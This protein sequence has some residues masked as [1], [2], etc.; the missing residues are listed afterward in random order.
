MRYREIKAAG[1]EKIRRRQEVVRCARHAFA[2]LSLASQRCQKQCLRRDSVAAAGPAA[3]TG[4][5]RR[6]SA[7]CQHRRR[8]SQTCWCEFA[9]LR[10]HMITTAADALVSVPAPAFNPRASLHEVQP[11]ML[12]SAIF[13][14]RSSSLDL[15]KGAG[16]AVETAVARYESVVVHLREEVEPKLN[17]FDAEFS[18][19]DQEGSKYVL[20]CSSRLLID[21]RT[22]ARSL[23]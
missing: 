18:V 21:Y 19:L 12:A 2:P 16:S 14:N 17:G 7:S 9:L 1:E 23:C 20:A 13:Q 11:A 6:V 3:D 4:H 10:P 15:L 8:C 22:Y 5:H